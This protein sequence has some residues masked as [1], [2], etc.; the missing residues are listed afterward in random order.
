MGRGWPFVLVLGLLLALT[1]RPAVACGAGLPDPFEPISAELW[2]G[3]GGGWVHSFAA[4]TTRGFLLVEAASP[5]DRSLETMT[6][7]VSRSNPGA[8]NSILL[9]EIP[10]TEQPVLVRYPV[11]PGQFHVGVRLSN[12]THYLHADDPMFQRLVRLTVWHEQP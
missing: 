3:P 7:W 10:L 9:D 2:V 6:L 1:A 12:H 4:P 8:C 5:P 11:E